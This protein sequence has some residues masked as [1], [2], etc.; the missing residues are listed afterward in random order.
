MRRTTDLSEKS[1]DH[2]DSDPDSGSDSDSSSGHSEP[3]YCGD[4]PQYISLDAS[5]A[6]FADCP[7]EDDSHDDISTSRGGPWLRYQVQLLMVSDSWHT[8][9]LNQLVWKT[10]K[11]Q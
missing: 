5:H 10:V 11:R 1:A 8:K 7:D 6:G 9:L 2:S 3:C 4:F